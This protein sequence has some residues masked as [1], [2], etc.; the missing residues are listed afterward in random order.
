M[1]NK[2]EMKRSNRH[3]RVKTPTVLQME[4][5]EC[6]AAALGIVLAY[7]GRIV[8]LEELRVACGVSRDGS[9]AS[10]ILRAAR[11]YGLEAHG[12]KKQPESLRATPLPTIIF[13]NF[14]H[15]LVVEGFGKGKVYLNDPGSGPRVVSEEEFDESYTGVAIVC[16]PAPEFV[17][18][19]KRPSLLKSLQQRLQGSETALLYVLLAS[20]ALIV[21]GL[22]VPSFIRVYVDNVL[23]G[24][25]D[26]LVM[27]LLGIMLATSAFVTT[28]TWL[29][30]HF[31]LR[32]ETKLALTTSSK[33]FWHVLRLPVVFFTQRAPGEISSRVGINDSVAGLLSG[34]LATNFLN[35]VLIIFFAILMFQYDIVL[36]MIGIS[37]AMLNLLALRFVSRKRVDG[38]RKL[39]QER[40]KLLGTAY[41]GLQSIE[42]L[43]A[44]GGE[45]DFFARWAGYQAKVMNSEQEL[46]VV[47]QT[48]S[49]VPPFLMSFNSLIILAIGGLRV[50]NGDMTMG[51]L[52][53]FQSL[54]LSFMTPVNQMVNLGSRLQ[55]A[56]GDMNRLDDVLRYPVDPQVK[57]QKIEQ[58]NGIIKLDGHIE[59]RNVTFGYSPLEAPLIE[60]FSLRVKSGTRVALVGSSGSGKSTVARLVV[61]LYE[62]WEGEILFDDSSSRDIPRP[63]INRSLAMVDQEIFLMAGS[64]KDNLTMWD[65]SVPEIDVIQAA[66][67]AHI[68]EEITNRTGGYDY[69]VAEGGGNFS[70]GQRQRIEIARALVSNPTILVLDEATSALDPVTEKVIDNN[71]RRRGCTCLIV[72]HRLSTIRDCDEIIVMDRGKVVQRGTHDELRRQKGLYAQLIKT[73]SQ[74][75]ES[76]IET[77]LESL[78]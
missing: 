75:T 34:E 20:V 68:H 30:Q 69:F 77:I 11:K 72:A 8:P 15:F 10:N 27:P 55:E 65:A 64:I 48:L 23:I 60:N 78:F 5:V 38:N 57:L 16:E 4:A 52:V 76:S 9:K 54:M 49:V 18:G 56:Q 25:F 45:S 32:L 13:W 36:T 6:G 63:I 74:E 61:G 14:N 58:T 24:G 40:G 7:Y 44:T 28:L 62:P 50:I 29:Q 73:E 12:Y 66:K 39:L 42:T 67:D 47:T 1:A 31:L 71:L 46:G 59:L 53:A 41:T 33:F 3:H 51:M 70:G 37:I 2:Q 21:P 26:D 35:L 43:K 17:K 19:G 22:I